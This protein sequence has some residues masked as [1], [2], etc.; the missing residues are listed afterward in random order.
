MQKLLAGT[1]M[2]RLWRRV[3]SRHF[4][5]TAYLMSSPANAEHL[6]RSLNSVRRGETRSVT[7][8]ELRKELRVAREEAREQEKA[9]V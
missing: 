3:F 9:R 5:E 4:D 6:R 1:R 8:D 2:H 7:M